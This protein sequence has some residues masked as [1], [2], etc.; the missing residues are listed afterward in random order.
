M[1]D[2]RIRVYGLSGEDYVGKCSGCNWEVAVLYYATREER[3]ADALRITKGE[4]P[5][6]LCAECF[7]N[8]CADISEI[9]SQ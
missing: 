8:A 5:Y 7:L 9:Q 1:C 6:G 3:D 4:R 2:S